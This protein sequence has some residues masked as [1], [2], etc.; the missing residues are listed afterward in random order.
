MDRFAAAT[1]GVTMAAG[2]ADHVWTP[3]EI[4]RLLDSN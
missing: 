3:T 4:A 1:S 2:V